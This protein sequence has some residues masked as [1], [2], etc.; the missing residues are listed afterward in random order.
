MSPH[1]FL[2]F[3]LPLGPENQIWR[4]FCHRLC[5]SP[6]YTAY[7]PPMG[8]E[9]QIWRKCYHRLCLRPI[10]TAYPPPL[11]PGSRESN[12][13]RNLSLSESERTSACLR[14]TPTARNARARAR[15]GVLEE[16]M[17]S[18]LITLPERRLCLLS[19]VAEKEWRP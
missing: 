13:K 2:E 7:P 6:I 18:V 9:N 17:S 16:I 5:L 4:E 12:I 1:G 14:P 15:A 11:G 19:G 10:Y 8:P 3:Y